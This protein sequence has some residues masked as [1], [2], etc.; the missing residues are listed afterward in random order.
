MATATYSSDSLGYDAR[1]WWF[2]DAFAVAQRNLIAYVRV[3][4]LLV[5]STI[6]PVIFVVMFR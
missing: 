3:P 5:F 2:W 1:A 4:Q 6:Q